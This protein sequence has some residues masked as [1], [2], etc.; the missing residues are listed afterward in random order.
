[1]KLKEAI[2]LIQFLIIWGHSSP[3]DG[4]NFKWFYYIIKDG[5]NLSKIAD[6]YDV[7]VQDL[8]KWNKIK[9]ADNIYFGKKIKIL[10]YQHK[11]DAKTDKIILKRPVKKW[12]IYK[13]YK[14]Y[15]DSKNH[16]IIYS[17]KKGETVYSAKE[18]RVVKIG[19]MRGYGKYI[20]VDHGS[21]WLS[22]YSN[23]IDISVQK[24]D[25]VKTHVPLGKTESN[26]LFFLI[27]H[28][29]EPVNP[30]YYL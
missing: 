20:L 6:R 14:N 1:M 18:G 11:K 25:Y 30:L 3:V 22:M 17:V 27:S 16:G 7:S 15:G 24:G 2:F 23:M 5:D 4:A 12:S 26:K 8:I 28:K 21:E 9:E 29:G 13:S 19:S 10:A